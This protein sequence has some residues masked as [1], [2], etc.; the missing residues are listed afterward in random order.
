MHI[1][2]HTATLRGEPDIEIKL[3]RSRQAKR[4][5]LRVSGL[6]GRVTLTIPKKLPLSEALAF[7]HE[8]ESWLRDAKARVQV[9]DRVMIGSDILLRGQRYRIRAAER[10]RC[11]LATDGRLL[12]PPDPDGQRTGPRLASY[13]KHCAQNDLLEACDAYSTKLGRR[14]TKLSLRDTRSRWGSC[15]SEG[16]RMFSWRLIM[17]PPGVLR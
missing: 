12:V 11:I 3:R 10:Q 17:A 2:N 14:F 8:R 15:S 5:N 7:L 4:L 6:D 13:F 16:R 9:S 1:E